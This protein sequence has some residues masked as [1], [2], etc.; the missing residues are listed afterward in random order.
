MTT[1]NYKQQLSWLLHLLILHGH[2]WL[3]I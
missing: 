1:T 3:D 2:Y